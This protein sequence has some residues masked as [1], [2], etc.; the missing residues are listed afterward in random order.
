MKIDH[1]KFID[2]YNAQYGASEGNLDGNQ[3]SG[4]RTLLGFFEADSNVS[5]VR[6]A[7]YMLATVKLECGDAWQP[8][9]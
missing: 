7:A 1:P 2:L 8:V 3:A 9:E 5:D 4:M 6:W